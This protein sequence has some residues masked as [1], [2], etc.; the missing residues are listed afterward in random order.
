LSELSGQEAKPRRRRVPKKRI[1]LGEI[2]IVSQPHSASLYAAAFKALADK[3]IQVQYHL[4]RHLEIGTCR[5][6]DDKR[7]PGAL[8][9]LLFVFSRVN[10]NDPWL[11][12]LRNAEATDADLAQLS[13][14][15]H[16]APEFRRFRY[17]F[18]A[19]HHTLYFEK[20]SADRK[21]LSPKA[22]VQAVNKLLHAEVLAGMFEEINAFSVSSKEAVEK[23]LH[24]N[25]L[26][27]LFIKL[28]RPNPDDDEFEKDVLFQM[29][30]ENVGVREVNS[31]KSAG[32]A[33]NHTERSN[34]ENCSLGRKIW[35]CY[36]QGARR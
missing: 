14:P 31:H 29:N 19:E 9:G 12:T 33:G 17:I 36:R 24:L 34:L 32:R 21:N 5:D 30:A 27:W 26:R 18:D 10:F 28:H 1:A 22:L 13:I 3:R 15:A 2:N 20:L 4:H 6:L 16:L 8:I 23:I 25:R 11:N 7:M 35:S